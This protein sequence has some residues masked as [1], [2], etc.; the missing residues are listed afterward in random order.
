[1]RT[2]GQEGREWQYPADADFA[3]LADPDGNLFF[4]IDTGQQPNTS[5]R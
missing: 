4:V 1:V 3:V 2:T 5:Q